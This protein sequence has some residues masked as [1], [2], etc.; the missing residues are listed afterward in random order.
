MSHYPVTIDTAFGL[1]SH[2]AEKRVN[3]Y[4]SLLYEF[5]QTKEQLGFIGGGGT[6]P[7]L[8]RELLFCKSSQILRSFRNG[9]RQEEYSSFKSFALFVSYTE[10]S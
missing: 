5:Q 6:S 10:M 1:S 7:K 9:N 3:F 8:F 4:N 2:T